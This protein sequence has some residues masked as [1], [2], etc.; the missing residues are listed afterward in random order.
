MPQVHKEIC[1]HISALSCAR[2]RLAA[3][4]VS[5]FVK[6][7]CVS[8]Y[9][10]VWPRSAH[11]PGSPLCTAQATLQLLALVVWMKAGQH[12]RCG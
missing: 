5:V 4:C 3:L 7:K 2:T 1:R 12:L 11:S 8:A 9:V 6:D 10:S